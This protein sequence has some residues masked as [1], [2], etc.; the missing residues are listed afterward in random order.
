MSLFLETFSI[1]TQDVQ[2]NLQGLLCCQSL[3]TDSEGPLQLI[4]LSSNGGQLYS[5]PRVKHLCIP[6]ML[7]YTI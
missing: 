2:V 6:L 1:Q 4:D 7:I 3:I 5:R